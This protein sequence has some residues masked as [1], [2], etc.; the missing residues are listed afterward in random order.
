MKYAQGCAGLIWFEACAVDF[1]E[2]RTHDAMLVIS[3]ETLPA[4]KKLIEE[5]KRMSETSL[6]ELGFQGRAVLILQLSH[7]GRQRAKKSERSPA[8]A[9]RFPELDRAIG[10][11]EKTG[12][13]I[14]D[15]ELEGLKDAY[16]EAASLALEAGFDAVDVKA[17]HGYLLNDLLSSYTRVG[18]YGGE[19]FEKRSKFFLDT[20]ATVKKEAGIAVT[21]RLSAYDGLPYPYGFGT[22]KGPYPRSS[23]SDRLPEYDLTEP[24]RLLRQM[25]ALGMDFVNISM[26]NPNYGPFLIRPFDVKVPGS[27]EPPEHP[28]KSVGRHFEVVEK[29]KREVPDMVF[30]GSGY[31]WLRQYSIYAASYNVKTSRTDLAGWGRLALALPTFPRIAF[32]KVALPSSKVCITCSACTRLLRAVFPSGCATQNP[33]AFKESMKRLKEMGK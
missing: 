29:L 13:V 28:V 26:G 21:S 22:S 12:R 27:S 4:F 5:V 6:S 16:G 3:R 32:S 10:V 1:P 8:L 17:C 33:E 23:P 14:T 18:V 11:T 9:Y 25:K 19:E 30:V 15:G 7:A 24:V 31:S 20:I 2:A